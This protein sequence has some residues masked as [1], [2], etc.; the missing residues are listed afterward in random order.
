MVHQIDKLEALQQAYNYTVQYPHCD[1]SDFKG[2]R[3]SIS[4]PWLSQQADEVLGKWDRLETRKQSKLTVVFVIGGPGV[5]KGTQ[6][7]LAA[8]SLN[9][10]HI[11]VGD[12]LRVEERNSQSVFSSFISESFRHSVVVP[13]ILT[14]QLLEQE[15]RSAE[16]LGKVGVLIDGFPRSLEQLEAF[17]QQ[18]SSTHLPQT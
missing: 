2:H 3:R 4:D 18:V 6:C 7:A 8:A 17:Q 16:E 9:F 1:L 10:V 14:M 13:A 15:L 12:L 5:G 11:S